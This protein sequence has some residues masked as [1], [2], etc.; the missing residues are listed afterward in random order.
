[1][2]ERLREVRVTLTE[3]SQ[4]WTISARGTYAGTW[5]ID[6]P[7]E[8]SERKNLSEALAVIGVLLEEENQT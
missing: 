7:N 4:S 3:G 2:T 5:E 6:A 1:M 8:I